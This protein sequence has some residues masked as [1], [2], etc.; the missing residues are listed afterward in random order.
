MTKNTTVK[1]LH[2]TDTG[3]NDK[4]LI[5]GKAYTNNQAYR[6]AKNGNLKGF[7]GVENQN[8]TK[9]IR[10]NPDQSKANNI[11]K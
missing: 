8:G 10:S 2:E 3:L 4:L 9:F 7:T 11:E 1:V 5:N 6:L